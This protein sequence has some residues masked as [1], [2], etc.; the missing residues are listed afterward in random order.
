MGKQVRFYMMPEDELMFLRAICQ[1]EEVILLADSSPMPEIQVI[2]KENLLVSPQ[3]RSK[4]TTILIWNRSFPIKRNDIREGRLVEY[5]EELGAYIET[6]DVLYF[7]NSSNAPVIEFSPSFLR[8]DGEL[9]QGRIWAEMYRLEGN[10]LV[11]KGEG[12]ES[13]YDQVARW[14]RRRF[15]RVEGVD[16]YLGPQA[17]KWYQEGGKLGR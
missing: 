5:R 11:Y 16:G 8:S 17:L 2:E 3:Q 14:L 1:S 9:T 10:A 13:W 4:L 12:F 7:I 6:G 15:K